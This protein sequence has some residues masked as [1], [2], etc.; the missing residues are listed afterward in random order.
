MAVL[1]VCG[2]WDQSMFEPLSLTVRKLCGPDL[3]A[4]IYRTSS[5]ALA[6]PELK[7]VAEQI[8]AATARA[9]EELVRD[10]HIKEDTMAA[11]TRELA[12]GALMAEMAKQWWITAIDEAKH[13]KPPVGALDQD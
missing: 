9:G 5:E 12:P 11:V 1:S 3:V 13:K 8:L 7:P 4:E 6:V 10:G 2:N